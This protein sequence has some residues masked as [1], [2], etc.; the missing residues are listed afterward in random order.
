LKD[1][2]IKGKE[3]QFA[4]K[5]S[6][7]TEERPLKSARSSEDQQQPGEEGKEVQVPNVMDITT[8]LWK[9]PYDRQLSQKAQKL[10]ATLRKITTTVAKQSNTPPNW[11]K[12]L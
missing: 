9:L 3:V 12:A 11:V 10:S 1:L 4:P 7:I 2:K 6:Q 8:P 5:K